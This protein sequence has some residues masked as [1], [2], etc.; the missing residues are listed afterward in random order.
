MHKLQ[1]TLKKVLIKVTIAACQNSRI[2]FSGVPLDG[3]NSL[4]FF[5]GPTNKSRKISWWYDSVRE[6]GSKSP[7]GFYEKQI[8]NKFLL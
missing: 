3:K 7:D 1:E 6:F 8:R 2:I 4:N 5:S